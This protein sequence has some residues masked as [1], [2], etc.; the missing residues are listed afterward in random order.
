MTDLIVP[1]G[2]LFFQ[3]ICREN[4][5]TDIGAHIHQTFFLHCC[6]FFT[7]II[8]HFYVSS[9]LFFFTCIFHSLYFSSLRFTIFFT[10]VFFTFV[11]RFCHFLFF[12]TFFFFTFFLLFFS[13]LFSSLL[14][15][16]HLFF[17]H[18]FLPPFFCHLFF[19]HL[20]FATMQEY[21][22]IIHIS[23][24]NVARRPTYVRLALWFLH[25]SAW[26]ESH[27]GGSRLTPTV[28]P[29]PVQ[30]GRLWVAYVS[31]EPNEPQEHAQPV[32]GSGA[33]V[34]DHDPGTSQSETQTPRQSTAHQSARFSRDAG[35]CHVGHN[36][37]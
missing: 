11:H 8:L 17:C 12:F 1:C 7:F 29:S 26:M 10:F 18:F 37:R 36:L 21:T 27:T 25:H 2:S 20:F 5:C 32:H 13:S 31:Y 35:E 14:F 19:C 30:L 15:F 9:L 23:S 34:Q 6:F 33:R 16:C 24:I 4:I 22:S 28:H 3:L